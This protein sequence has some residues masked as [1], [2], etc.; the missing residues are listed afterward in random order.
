MNNYLIQKI[1]CHRRRVHGLS[2]AWHLAMELK[3]RGRGS[4]AD[5]VVL[6]KT[7][8]GPALRGSPAA[9]CEIST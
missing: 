9:V 6:D 7:G 3:K 1:C 4:G 5:V 8:P 2:S